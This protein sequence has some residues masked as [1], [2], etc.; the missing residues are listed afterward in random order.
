MKKLIMQLNDGAPGRDGVTAKS[1]KCI[2]DHIAMP[3][4]RLANLSFTQSIFPRDR[5]IAMV[6]PLY[7]AKDPMIFRN[8]R[9]ISLLSSF[10]KILE[11]LM[12]NRLLNFLN[13]CD[14]LNK[15]QFRFR[16]N[17]STYMALAILLENLHNAQDKGECPI[18]TFLD[19][20]KAFDTVNHGI[21][22]D[23]LSHHS[24]RGPAYDWFSSYL[25]MSGTSLLSIVAVNQNIII[26]SVE[27]LKGQ[28]LDHCFFLFIL[29]ICHLFPVCPCLYCLQMT[30]KCFPRAMGNILIDGHQISEVKETK[31]LGVIVNNNLK[32]C[33]H[34]QY[35]SRKKSKGICVMVKARKVFEQNTL[36]SLYNSLMLP[37]LNYYIHVWGKAYNTHLNH[38]IKMKKGCPFNCGSNTP[39][40]YC[41]IVF[42]IGYHAFEIIIHACHWLMHVQI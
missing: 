36:L 19:F 3:L 37:C 10:S 8:Y 27:S 18:G 22:L 33:A 12:S 4:S 28:Y 15:Y 21:L 6:S 31:F 40:K 39:H 20:Q 17:H 34:I 30:P 26:Y 16:N 41:H 29:M 35:I 9:P 23:K 5:K 13:N 24:I 11:K 1:L 14:I 32:W 7:K 25:I 42:C 2:T 38:L